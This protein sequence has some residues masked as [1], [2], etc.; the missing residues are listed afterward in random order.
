MEPQFNLDDIVKS[1]EELSN[2]LSKTYNLKVVDL[3]FTSLSHYMNQ[4]RQNKGFFGDEIYL[5]RPT[6]QG[7]R[8]VIKGMVSMI[9]FNM[10]HVVLMLYKD[11]FSYFFLTDTNYRYVKI[12][13]DK[14]QSTNDMEC[15]ICMEEQYR[16][17]ACMKCNFSICQSCMSK[18]EGNNCP[19]CRGEFIKTNGTPFVAFKDFRDINPSTNQ[20]PQTRPRSRS[21]KKSPRNKPCP[22]GSGKKYKKCCGK[23]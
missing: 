13:M 18:L 21:T 17:E 4:V 11:N 20:E 2:F 19:Q 6:S 14:W 5:I 16:F 23:N 12:Q 10:K 22:C 8:E 9:S 3:N 7:N 15:P 1:K